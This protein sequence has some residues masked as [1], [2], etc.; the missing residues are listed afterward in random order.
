MQEKYTQSLSESQASG[1][2]SDPNDVFFDTVGG[3]RK[4]EVHGFGRDGAFLYYEKSLRR[5][6]GSGYS[7]SVSAQLTQMSEE[8]VRARAELVE[9]DRQRDEE[10]RRL[11]EIDR[12]R[13]EERVKEHRRLS[14]RERLREEEHRLLVEKQKQQEAYMEQMKAQM[15]AFM[16]LF[17]DP[18]PFPGR[19]PDDRTDGSGD[20]GAFIAF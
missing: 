18:P 2:P 3:Y 1:S 15:D 20:S 9:R 4:G 13:E 5:H 11:A 14:E 16:R 10:H 17:G 12:Q 6:D 7:P 8:L 19:F